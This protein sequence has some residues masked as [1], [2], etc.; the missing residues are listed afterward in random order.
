MS[1]VAVLIA[2][3]VRAGVDPDLI[4]RTAELLSCDDQAERR[5][6]AD[7]DRKRASRLSAVS[8]ESA[9]SAPHPPA[10]D[11]EN[12]PAPPEEINPTPLTPQ[13]A[14]QGGREA[15]QKSDLESLTDKL[16]EA[17]GDKIQPHGAIVLAPVLGLID[18]GCD[19]ETDILPTIRARAAKLVRPA[20]SWAYFVQ[21]IREA[22]ETRIAAGKGL[23]RPKPSAV[24]RD[25]D[26]TDDERRARLTK[27]LRMA[28]GSGIW[29]T[30]MH[31]PPPGREGCRVPP[32]LLEDRDTRIDWFEEKRPEAA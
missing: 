29:L 25:E 8:A 22:Y 2:D 21:A 3:M 27:F 16:L 1:A 15:R 4:G 18:G 10:L 31:G 9:D 17:A 7:R 6:A 11:K 30:W 24:K 23:S 14:L 19:L 32:D 5:R 20:G 26:M 13:A 12:P 28:R